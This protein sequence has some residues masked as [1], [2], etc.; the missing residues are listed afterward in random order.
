MNPFLL[1]QKSTQ[2]TNQTG[3]VI[4][5]REGE[6]HCCTIAKLGCYQTKGGGNA[7]AAYLHYVVGGVA[8][9]RNLKV[10][11][12]SSDALLYKTNS[13]INSP[14]WELYLKRSSIGWWAM[15]SPP[16]IL[17]PLFCPLSS[18]WTNRQ[19]CGFWFTSTFVRRMGWP[20]VARPALNV[21]IS[22]N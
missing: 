21:H 14:N 3:R 17:P 6:W 16:F 4:R 20:N 15:S 18:V 7:I 13:S 1:P 19:F 10:P 8:E 5:A 22:R 2:L 12:I 11:I 9:I